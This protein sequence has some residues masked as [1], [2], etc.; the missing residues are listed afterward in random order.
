MNIIVLGTIMVGG[1]ILF[2]FVGNWLINKLFPENKE[3]C[4]ICFQDK[5]VCKIKGGHKN[6]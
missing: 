5:D 4:S 1:L 3:V 6:D 2:Y